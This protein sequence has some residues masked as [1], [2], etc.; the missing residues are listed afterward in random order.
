[1]RGHQREAGKETFKPE[2]MWKTQQASDN[3]GRPLFTFSGTV[4]LLYFT[5][6]FALLSAALGAANS[7]S[8]EGPKSGST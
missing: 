2:H 5:T 4:P 6:T 7:M 3:K 8:P 1:M